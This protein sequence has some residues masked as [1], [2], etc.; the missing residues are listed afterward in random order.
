MTQESIKFNDGDGTSDSVI[1]PCPEMHDEVPKHNIRRSDSHA[2]SVN[3]EHLS[4]LTVPDIAS[5][6]ISIEKYATE[7][8]KM[9]SD[10]L[11]EIAK[12][13]ILNDDQRF[14]GTATV[15]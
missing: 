13:Q 14:D 5:V 12:H 10:Q 3:R 6:P 9:I 2:F 8:Q 7:L 15:K 11:E 4:S 1:Y